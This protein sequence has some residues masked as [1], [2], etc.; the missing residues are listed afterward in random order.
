MTKQ[1]EID[2]VKNTGGPDRVWLNEKPLRGANVHETARLLRDFALIAE[3]LDL[4]EGA[5]VLDLGCGPG[6]TSAFLARMGYIVTG[7]DLAP[8][9][10]ALAEKRAAREGVSERCT[11]RVA[12]SESSPFVRTTVVNPC[13]AASSAVVRPATPLPSTRTSITCSA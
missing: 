12:D 4:P 1:A 5:R 13:R 2:Y 6:W 9:M 7:T 8:D 10:I 3:T 11:F